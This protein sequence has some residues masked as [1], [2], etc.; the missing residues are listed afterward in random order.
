MK[1]KPIEEGL[2]HNNLIII[3]RNYFSNYRKHRY[4]LMDEEKSHPTTIVL[5]IELA[6]KVIIYYRKTT[7][8]EFRTKLGF[9]Q[10]DAILTTDQ[11][12]LTKIMT[13]FEGYDM[14]IE[15]S[16]LGYRISF[17]FHDNKRVIKIDENDHID[18]KVTMN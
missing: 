15:Y 11:S 5:R 8:H 6:I 17:Y 18:G 13:S 12:V 10:Y 14:K 2:G 7:L 1:K 4:E 16:V 3:T 9:R